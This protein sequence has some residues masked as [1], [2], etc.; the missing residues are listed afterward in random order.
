LARLLVTLFG[1]VGAA[2]WTR[3]YLMSVA[4]AD[5]LLYYE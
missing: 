1:F 4:A 2:T 3:T 5:F